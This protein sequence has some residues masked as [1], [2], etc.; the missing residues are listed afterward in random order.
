MIQI[1]WVI[2]IVRPGGE[3]GCLSEE[4]TQ[5]VSSKAH[6]VEKARRQITA[7]DSIWF[8]GNEEIEV[9]PAYMAYEDC[10]TFKARG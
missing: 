9:Y 4:L 7:P 10:E 8:E 2:R 3:G 1:G 5:Y 6:A